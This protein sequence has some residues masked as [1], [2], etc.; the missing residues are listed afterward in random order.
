MSKR[1]KLYITLIAITVLTIIALEMTKPKQINWFESYALHHKIPFGSFVFK[2][3]LQRVSKKVKLVE[4]PPFEY[5][6]SNS[7]NGTYIFYNDVINFGREELNSLLDWVDKGNTLLVS[8]TDFEPMLL[9]TL[10]LKTLSVNTI[11]NFNNEYKV[12]LVN[13]RLDNNSFKYDKPT[14]FYHFNKIDTL[15]TN[16][17]GFIDAYRNPQEEAIKDSLVNIIKQPFG[18]G[19]IILS[20][21]PQAFTNY[22]ILKTPNHNYTASLLSYINTDE[23]IFVDTYYKSGKKFYTSPMYLFLN[24]RALKW[25]YYIVLIC[26]LI[27]IVFEGKRKQRAIPI[28][29]PLKNQTVSFTRTIANMYYEKGKNKDIAKHK[30]QH[31]LEYIRNTMYLQTAT[32]DAEF[33]KNLAARSNNTLEDTETVF[34]FISNIEKQTTVNNIE[35]ERLNTLIDNFKSHNQ[36]KTKP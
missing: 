17:V 30:I 19:T 1:G 3:Q 7:A 16:V 14:T 31:F 15:K 29:T 5:L 26:V 32:I 33:I 9:D 2:E 21:F 8:A 18:D 24:N 35:L 34:N 6:K 36:W 25:A 11:G 27:Y 10:H 4:R 22:F 23:P 13:P 12:Q 20:T 28:I